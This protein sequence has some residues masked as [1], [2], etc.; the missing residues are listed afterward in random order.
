MKI[1]TIRDKSAIE[2]RKNPIMVEL[3]AGNAEEAAVPD[4]LEYKPF[5]STVQNPDRRYAADRALWD[6]YKA[7]LLLQA[8][9]ERARC[10][11]ILKEYLDVAPP[12]VRK[13][14]SE[15]IRK[16]ELPVSA[17]R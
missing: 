10:S 7:S 4:N 9:Q 1:A 15:L 8:Q 3:A 16:I 6:T 2:K 11:K 5:P 14:V 12:S 13:D 17:Y